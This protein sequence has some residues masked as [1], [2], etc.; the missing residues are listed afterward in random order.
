MVLCR[1]LRQSL[2]DRSLPTLLV[3][4]AAVL[5]FVPFAEGAAEST[6]LKKIRAGRHPA[7]VRLV[8]ELEGARPLAAGPVTD[9]GFPLVFS[10]LKSRLGRDGLKAKWPSPVDSIA[11]EERDGSSV[12]LIAWKGGASSVRHHIDVR[13]TKA[14]RLVVEIPTPDSE[15]GIP[16]AEASRATGAHDRVRETAA[17]AKTQALAD[18]SA[19]SE[20]T[21]RG[22]EMFSQGDALYEEHEK[23]LAPA[24]ARIIEEY[25]S[26]LRSNPQA[27]QAVQAHYRTGLCHLALRDFR[28]AEESFKQILNNHSRHPLAPFAWMRLGE[29][30]IKR[31]AYIESIQAL[32][33]SLNSP[34]EQSVAAEAN[35]Y[36]G[37]ALFLLGAHKEAQEVLLKSLADDPTGPIARPEQLRFLGE[38]YFVNRDFEKSAA[39]LMWYINLEKE[40]PGKD[41]LLAKIG[42][43]LLYSNDPDL[44]KK[45][46]LYIDKYYPETEG[47]IISKIR[48]AEYFERQNPPNTVAA[49]A[50]YEELAQSTVTGPLGEYLTYKLA[51]WERGRRNYS[52]AL[53]RI[54]QGLANQS[55]P[56]AREE[57]LDLKVQVLLEYIRASH[58]AQDFT[59]IFELFD[60]NREILISRMTSETWSMV[61]ESCSMLRLHSAAAEIYRRLYT[62]S[63]PKS[64]EWLL[65]AARCYFQMGDPERTISSCLP[66]QD[67]AHQA[68]KTALLGRAYFQTGRYGQA[69][70]ELFKHIE[71]NNNLET[72]DPDVLY[73]YAE[74]LIL[75][76]RAA[77]ALSFL[78]KLA[79][80]PGFAEGEPR[81]RIGVMQSRALNALRQFGRAAEVLEELLTL[82]PPEPIR[83]TLNYELSRIYQETGQTEKAFERLSQLAQSPNSLW[84]AAAEQQIGYLQLNGWKP[85]AAS[86]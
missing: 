9:L 27:R 76:D 19:E 68:E 50:I 14:Y 63:E 47:H 74:S 64:E 35:A 15:V 46:Y 31:G 6:I 72:V 80:V 48:R 58:A 20:A 40:P 11:I 18:H 61:A 17:A 77:D 49:S 78:D 52:G 86:K 16:H 69:A 22:D 32:R 25:R 66:L 28:K 57:L 65:K 45:I 34:L 26:A 43:S 79:R 82:S 55:T 60:G 12:I 37:Q 1:H 39:T 29:A 53:K 70:Q 3:A 44:A 73:G 13:G 5:L 51:S 54:D 24:A 4:W 56:K 85:K 42:E 38:A 62:E 10:K 30:L 23:N 83:D 8:F 33:T 7:Q 75:S 71:K 84:K 21:G 41:L 36:L 59:E 67:Q 81:I 2:P